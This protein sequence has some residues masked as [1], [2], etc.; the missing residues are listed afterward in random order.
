MQYEVVVDAGHGGNEPGASSHGIVEKQVVLRI[1]KYLVDEL[2]ER[3][4][5]AT[6]TRW[7]DVFI[8]LSHRAHIANTRLADAFLSLH[9]NASGNP[10]VTGAQTFHCAGSVKGQSLAEYCQQ[11]LDAVFLPPTRWTGVFPDDSPQC[12][13]RKLTVL[14][15]TQ[16][17]AAL[18]EMG[19]VTNAMDR[20]IV[21]TP[22]LQRAIASA[23]ADAVKEWLDVQRG[24]V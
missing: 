17:P 10:S 19:F 7:D 3:D 11:G 8:P 20:A 15:K 13:N 12:G 6:M 23:V 1:A 16:M 2:A 24:I 4:V 5:L 9:L 18:L 14:R 22:T 21:T